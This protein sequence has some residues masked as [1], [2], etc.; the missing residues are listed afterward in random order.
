MVV[1]G[2]VNRPIKSNQEHPTEPMQG[3]HQINQNR[4]IPYIYWTFLANIQSKIPRITCKYYLRIIT[5]KRPQFCH[6]LKY[7]QVTSHSK[8]YFL[9]KFLL[10]VSSILYLQHM[11]IPNAIR[12]GMIVVNRQTGRIFVLFWEQ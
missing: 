4:K 6:R 11:A 5:L 10:S 12:N 7:H 9:R 8:W 3:S 1:F 2:K